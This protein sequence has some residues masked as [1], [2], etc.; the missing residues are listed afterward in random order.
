M[1]RLEAEM[2]EKQLNLN[3]FC[4][5]SDGFLFLIFIFSVVYLMD[6]FFLFFLFFQKKNCCLAEKKNIALF[7]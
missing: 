1:E 3:L 7:T 5:L 4:C 6:S 2:V